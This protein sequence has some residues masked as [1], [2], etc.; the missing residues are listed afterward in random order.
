MEGEGGVLE[1]VAI[2]RVNQ[3]FIRRTFAKRAL[4]ELILLRHLNHRNVVGIKKVLPL[5]KT[6]SELFIVTE[7]RVG[8]CTLHAAKGR[9][10]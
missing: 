7:V 8:A 6:S 1:K 4:R 3:P 9:S 10:I 2:K 5:T